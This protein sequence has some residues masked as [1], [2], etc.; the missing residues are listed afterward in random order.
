M[1]IE[2]AFCIDDNFA[3]YFATCI[4]SIKEHSS[5]PVRAHVIGRLHHDTKTKI[6]TLAD[7]N[8][9]FNFINEVPN[10]DRL[11]VSHRYGTRLNQI[12]Y[13][14]FALADL[15][16]NVSKLLYLDADILVSDDLAPL[17]NID[18]DDVFAAVVEDHSLMAQGYHDELGEGIAAYFNAGMMLINLDL[19]RSHKIKR[20]L[21]D[22]IETRTYW[23][24]NDQDVLN[25][26]LNE[27]V[28]YIDACYNSQTYTIA[29][30]LVDSPVV[31]HFTGQ[32]K[33]WHASSSH[34]YT[35]KFREHLNSTPF[36]TTRFDLVLDSE[37]N[38]ILDTLYSTLPSGGKLVL[39]GAGARGRRLSMSI[40]SYSS[41]YTIT[42]FIDSV[43]QG[44]WLDIPIYRPDK[45]NF[46]DVDALIIATLPAR[47]HIVNSLHEASYIII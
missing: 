46:D 45:A 10:Y 20:Q 42:Y 36:E 38:K 4:H 24:F 43:L 14:R 1:T 41:Q 33:P 37:D 5:Q 23:E 27:K 17:W 34:P 11:S 3:P 35:D 29:N 44:S 19:W 47:Q 8:V 22:T 39:W 25:I 6:L 40:L 9:K 21:I 26:V 7:N 15:L 16:P 31:V 18:I 28:R 32:E 12:T 2:L 13:W 30:G